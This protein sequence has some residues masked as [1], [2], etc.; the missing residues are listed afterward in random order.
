MDGQG[1]TDDGLD[2]VAGV[3]TADRI[4]KDDLQVA[5]GGP[6]GGRIQVQKI[7]PLEEYRSRSGGNQAENGSGQRGLAAAALADQAQGLAAADL[8]ADSVHGPDLPDHA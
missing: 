3:E 8:Q 7:L 5:A 1:F 4:L 6:Q 2:G